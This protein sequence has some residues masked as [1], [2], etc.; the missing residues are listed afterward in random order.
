[1]DKWERF[2][3]LQNLLETH[4]Q[5]VP[6]KNLAERLECDPATIKRLV[7]EF[8]AK[9]DAP[10]ASSRAGYAWRPRPD[11]RFELPGTWLGQAELLALMV[12]D[13]ALASLGSRIMEREFKALRK[14]VQQMLKADAVDGEDFVR[15]LRVVSSRQRVAALPFFSELVLALQQRQQLQ[16][17]Y[18]S[19]ARNA[20]ELRM[21]SPQRLVLYR[22]NW[23]LDGWCH[24]RNALRT[25]ALDAVQDC[26]RQK[27]PARELSDSELDQHFTH[28]YGIFSGAPAERAEL[29][30]SAEAARWVQ[31]EVWHPEQTL[32][33][34]ADGRL[35]L[36]VPYANPTELLRDVLA[37]GEQVEVLAPAS[38]RSTIRQQLQA[39]LAHYPA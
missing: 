16:F 26:R 4:R 11:Q 5:P 7:A 21:V 24:T 31:A 30:F 15:R 10:I 6:L 20:R 27:T 23:Y 35:Q 34:L 25:F 3:Q 1:M 37:W 32:Q 13:N 29:L 2:R 28:S 39:A 22:D 33:W 9:Y 12:L 19:R 14:K 17:E 8:R 38:L 36:Q 18:F